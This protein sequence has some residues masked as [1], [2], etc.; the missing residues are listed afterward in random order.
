MEI[1]PSAARITANPIFVIIS[2]CSI[3]INIDL[4]AKI[5][6]LFFIECIKASFTDETSLDFFSC[7]ERRNI[8]IG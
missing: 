3:V 1:Y 5:T 4:M 6:K 7:P 2:S 8:R